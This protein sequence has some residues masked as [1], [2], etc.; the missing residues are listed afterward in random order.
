VDAAY[1]GDM[2][3]PVWHLSHS[4]CL[5]AVLLYVSLFLASSPGLEAAQ[6]PAL[7]AAAS[8]TGV[9]VEGLGKAVEPLTGPWQ[10]HLGDD[11]SWASPSFDDSQWEKLTAAKSWGMQGHPSYTGYAW[12]RLNLSL[13]L[14]PSNRSDLDL[15]VPHLDDVYEIFWN[16]NSI[17]RSGKFP[18]DPIWYRSSNAPAIYSL[19]SET[20]PSE[21]EQEHVLSGTI[22]IR[23]WKAPLLSDASGLSG[24]FEAAPVIGYPGSVS[25][26]KTT[27]DY[28]WLRANQVSLSEYLLYGIAGLLSLVSWLRDRLQ[29]TLLWMTG[30]ALS[31]VIRLVLYGLR[32]SWPVGLSNALGPPISG[33]YPSGFSCSGFFISTTIRR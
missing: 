18:P 6:A 33:T 13:N 28:Q 25:A 24:G 4:R 2:V 20:L 15:L 10:F 27:L 31:P 8:S 9:S 22:A 32:I 29:R 26:Y 14:A 3:P 21:P 1:A 19:R 30:F 23:V 16:G 17:G 5:P 11:P 7:S 12:Y